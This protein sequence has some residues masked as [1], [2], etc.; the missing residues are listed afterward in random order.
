[1]VSLLLLAGAQ[2][3][4]VDVER[5]TA[6]HFVGHA[7]NTDLVEMMVDGAG[8]DVKTRD[9]DGWTALDLAIAKA[10]KDTQRFLGDRSELS[11]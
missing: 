7:G 9:A 11:G 6:L 8:A 4:L 3:N 2:I 10:H 5:W 1:M